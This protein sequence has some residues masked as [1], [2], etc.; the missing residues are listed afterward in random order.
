MTALAK[1][2]A[3]KAVKTSRNIMITNLKNV[4]AHHV[5]ASRYVRNGICNAKRTVASLR[6]VKYAVG[7]SSWSLLVAAVVLSQESP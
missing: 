5:L 2:K 7:I 6:I 4:I 1:A 3:V